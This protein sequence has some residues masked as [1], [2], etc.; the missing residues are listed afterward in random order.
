MWQHHKSKKHGVGDLQTVTL[1]EL[2]KLLTKTSDTEDLRYI[3][4]PPFDEKRESLALTRTSLKREWPILKVFGSGL[5]QYRSVLHAA[6]NVWQM[7]PMVYHACRGL[8]I[9]LAIGVAYSMPVTAE[10]ARQLRPVVVVLSEAQASEFKSLLPQSARIDGTYTV[11]V[12]HLYNGAPHTFTAFDSFSMRVLE[13]IPGF[14]LIYTCPTTDD[15]NLWHASDEYV[16]G[17]EENGAASIIPLSAEMPW[18][19]KLILPFRLGRGSR[20]ACGREA[21][22]YSYA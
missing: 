22:A 7:E 18:F 11:I 2:S 5:A 15:H 3:P 21:F 13:L 9:P 19:G 10:M 4:L 1:D 8:G 6:P 16:W 14:P 17:K 12:Q 20:C